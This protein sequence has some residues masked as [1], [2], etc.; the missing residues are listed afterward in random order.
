MS[1]SLT[2]RLGVKARDYQIMSQELYAHIRGEKKY[3]GTVNGDYPTVA[4]SVALT[5]RI[6]LFNYIDELASDK[7]NG[8]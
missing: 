6:F 7:S 2:D 4:S 8:E 3:S 1:S 5:S